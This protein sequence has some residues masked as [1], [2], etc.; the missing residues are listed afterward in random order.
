MV[1]NLRLN[2]ETWSLKK[3]FKMFGFTLQKQEVGRK[4]EKPWEQPQPSETK[5]AG[6]ET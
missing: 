5:M 4:T 3:K 1:V 2:Q 6:L